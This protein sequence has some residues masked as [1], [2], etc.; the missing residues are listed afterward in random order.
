MPEVGHCADDVIIAPGW[1]LAGELE[2]PLFNLGR[3]ERS[4]RFGCASAGKI[5]FAGGQ[6]AVPFE[7]G[8]GLH[9]GNDLAQQLAEGLAFFGEHLAL[10]LVEARQRGECRSSRAR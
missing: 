4:S 3:D 2:H 1:I 8:F 7:Q 10:G 9:D 6:A 5:P